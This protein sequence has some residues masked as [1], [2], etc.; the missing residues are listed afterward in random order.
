[1]DKDKGTVIPEMVKGRKGKGRKVQVVREEKEREGFL[2]R[3][4]P[5]LDL[6]LPRDQKPEPIYRQR[7][8][9]GISDEMNPNLEGKGNAQGK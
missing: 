1:M 9:K 8:S 2:L 3:L 7:R 6:K 5:P 4:I